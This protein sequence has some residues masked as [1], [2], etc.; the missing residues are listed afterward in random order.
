MYNTGS[1]LSKLNV[2]NVSGNSMVFNA[3]AETSRAT[4]SRAGGIQGYWLNEGGTK[5]ASKPAF[6]QI[7]LKLKKVAA[8]SYA[9]DELLADTSALDSFLMRHMAD[10]L[11][12]LVEDAVIEGSGAGQPLGILNSGALV[13]STRTNANE[14]A[15]ADIA[16]MWARRWVG[17]N[18]Y[19][20]LVD[21]T[22]IPQLSALTVGNFPLWIPGNSY[23][24]APSGTLYG[25]PILETE[26]T[27]ALGTVGD[28]LLV[29]FGEIAA[30]AK[31]GVELASSIHVQF[32][33]DE[34]AFRAVY[35]F[36]SMPF[37]KTV[38]TPFN[39]SSDTVS[40]FVALAATT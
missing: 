37:W 26:Y 11:R 3:L 27:K 33:T 12:F 5:T 20:W 25:R 23:N 2:T 24:N 40:P 28:I 4:G 8:V 15:A 13:S 22:V 32:L 29:S 1:I 19:V 39:G 10:E 35:R 16:R 34:Q 36:D 30:I 38:L 21:P 9:S 17:A 6:E 31:G 14:V 7:A 18:D